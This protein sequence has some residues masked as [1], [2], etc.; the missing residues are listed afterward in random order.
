MKHNVGL[1]IVAA[2]RWVDAVNA[3]QDFARLGE[4]C[5]PAMVV[6]RMG[7][8]DKKGK[9]AETFRGIAEVSAWLGRL[10]DGIEFE[11]AGGPEVAPKVGPG[12]WRV[13]YLYRIAE[14]QF[15]NGG[16]W[17][18]RLGDDGRLAW[19]RHDPDPL[20]DEMSAGGVDHGGSDSADHSHGDEHGP[21]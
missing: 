8:F 1:W 17:L 21:H 16:E 12:V 15:S 4:A 19:L 14:L 11:L 7:V 5:V 2:A 13:R 6:E 20:P 9:L 18:M 10:P 3:P